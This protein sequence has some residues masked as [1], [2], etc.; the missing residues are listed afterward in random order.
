MR[1]VSIVE[2]SENIYLFNSWNLY[3]FLVKKEES[4]S[5]LSI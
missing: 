4:R 3:I 5:L 2:F 1:I